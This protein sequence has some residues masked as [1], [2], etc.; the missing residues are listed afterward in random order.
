MARKTFSAAQL[1]ELAAI[2]V[3]IEIP[4]RDTCQ[5]IFRHMLSAKTPETMASTSNPA[6]ADAESKVGYLGPN[7]ED[8]I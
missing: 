3:K 4:K 7:S 6:E 2:M 1:G 8:V 5:T